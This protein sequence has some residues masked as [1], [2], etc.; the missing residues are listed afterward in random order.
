MRWRS[1]LFALAFTVLMAAAGVAQVGVPQERINNW[2]DMLQ[3]DD[4]QDRSLA[5]LSLLNADNPA[6][7]G[8]IKLNLGSKERPATR[9]SILKAIAIKGDERLVTDMIVL[10][11]DPDQKVADESAAALGSLRSGQATDLMTGALLNNQYSLLSRTKLARILADMRELRAVPALIE[12]L[13]APEDPLK[14]GALESLEKL[15]QCTYGFNQPAW[16]NWWE[17]WKTQLNR[18]ALLEDVIR[19]QSDSLAQLTAKIGELWIRL[20]EAQPAAK[21]PRPYYEALESGFPDVQLYAIKWLSKTKPEGCV[22]KLVAQSVSPRSEVRQAIAEALGEMRG[23]A[24]VP[25]LVQLLSDPEPKVARQVAMSLGRLKAAEAV[26]GL[27]RLLGANSAETAGA[28]AKALGE[29]GDPK[30]AEALSQAVLNVNAERQVREDAAAALGKIGGP[31]A[32]KSLVAS[33]DDADVRIR[34][35]AADS[36]GRLS[37]QEAL[38]GLGRTLKDDKDPRVR[39]VAANALQRIRSEE[40]IP[41]LLI[42]MDDAEP[43]VASQS[44][45]AILVI[46]GG[47]S[48]KYPGLVGD[49]LKTDDGTKARRICE[50]AIEAI[51]KQDKTKDVT[52]LQR[53]LGQVLCSTRKWPEARTLY[54]GLIAA[55]PEDESAH[56]KQAECALRMGD[57]ATALDV[58]AMALKK[59]PASADKWWAFVL[60]TLEEV[61]R[62]EKRVLVV[63]FI[64]GIDPNLLKALS[65]E[66]RNALESLKTVAKTG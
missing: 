7:M 41:S 30:A 20:L 43:R 46:Y 34:W 53:L 33:L 11:D 6:A 49:L 23:E 50:A 31:A 37:S 61:A 9:I 16:R 17:Q 8:V 2:R 60:Q 38:L 10:L 47:D 28:A 4:P 39:E 24:I 29:I 44:L 18:E 54:E 59:F 62:G 36:L 58:C 14:R 1:P 48:E 40:A 51:Q 12:L 66:R 63:K 26:N 56:M 55:N 42:G 32:V 27:I 64:D 35:Q 57:E 15:T 21:D 22:D 52:S 45:T 19:R 5:A 13:G 3:H 65:E 25:A